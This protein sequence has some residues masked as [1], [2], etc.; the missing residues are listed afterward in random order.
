MTTQ[1]GDL[2]NAV[3][4]LTKHLFAASSECTGRQPSH[5]RGNEYAD[6]F[7]DG[8]DDAL[9][10]LKAILAAFPV[11]HPEPTIITHPKPPLNY[12]TIG[13]QSPQQEDWEPE[14]TQ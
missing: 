13:L 7:E 2:R 3:E 5:W 14:A 12:A 8:H 1:Y 10:A 6:G 9:D 11:E 4:E